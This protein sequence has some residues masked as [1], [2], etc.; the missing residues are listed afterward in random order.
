LV[1]P[2]GRGWAW[3]IRRCRR[4]SGTNPPSLCRWD[5]GVGA[6][7][8]GPHRWVESPVARTWGSAARSRLQ[9]AARTVPGAGQARTGYQGSTT[10]AEA[11]LRPLRRSRRTTSPCAVRSPRAKSTSATWPRG[12]AV[13]RRCR[14]CASN[15]AA[16]S[17]SLCPGRPWSGCDEEVRS[18]RV[19]RAH[20]LHLVS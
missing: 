3:I 19:P 10:S 12:L 18:A 6:G 2:G 9:I 20:S 7:L 1:I 5:G 4:L 14:R 8:G 17:R 15:R 13:G 16:P 11:S